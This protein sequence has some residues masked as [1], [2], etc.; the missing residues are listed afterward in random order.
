MSKS[1]YLIHLADHIANLE[2]IVAD[3][4]WNNP[5]DERLDSLLVALQQ[6]R[7]DLANGVVWHPLF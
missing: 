3:I 5:D 4:E 2:T 7:K 6:A 1:P